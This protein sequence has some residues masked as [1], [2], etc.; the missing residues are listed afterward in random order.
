MITVNFKPL[1]AYFAGSFVRQDTKPSDIN[2]EICFK[3]S[4]LKMGFLLFILSLPA[5]MFTYCGFVS[6]PAYLLFAFPLIIFI[7]WAYMKMTKRNMHNIILSPA[8]M[9]YELF[10]NTIRKDVLNWSEIDSIESF[11]L[12]GGNLILIQLKD[13]SQTSTLGKIT[14]PSF[15]LNLNLDFFENAEHLERMIYEMYEHHKISKLR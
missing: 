5:I 12:R 8:G 7:A 4:N 9:K 3:P 6:S 2:N 11:T 15:D 10:K 1:T 14:N 13:R